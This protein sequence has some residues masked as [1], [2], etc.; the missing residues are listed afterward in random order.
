MGGRRGGGRRRRGRGKQ[1]VCMSFSAFTMHSHHS[2][3]VTGVLY[4]PSGG[5]IF[6]CSAS[7]SLAMYCCH[8]IHSPRL[9]RLLANTVAKGEEY[10]PQ[11]LTLN[12]DGSRLAFVGPHN[13]TISVLEADT[14]NEVL[15]IDITPVITSQPLADS[16]KLVCYSP[17]ALNQILVVT[18]LAKLLKFSATNGQLLSE[19]GPVHRTECLSVGVSGNGR[20]LVTG[21]DKVVKVW[22]YSMALSLNFQVSQ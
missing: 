15:R 10:G 5:Q 20:Y 17:M 8:D 16:A 1:S 9:I 11:A 13:F 12:E 7:G 18:K 4:S 6:S 14:L 21:G 2:G 19:V 22:D 3:C